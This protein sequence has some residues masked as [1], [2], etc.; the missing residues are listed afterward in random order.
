M[1]DESLQLPT[2]G[3]RI[4]EEARR[5]CASCWSTVKV[6]FK[7]PEPRMRLGVH[8]QTWTP[9]VD[10]QRRH[11]PKGKRPPFPVMGMLLSVTS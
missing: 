10:C 5:Q 9:E 1:R 7:A 6:D 3:Q 2:E 4:L 8:G 11:R